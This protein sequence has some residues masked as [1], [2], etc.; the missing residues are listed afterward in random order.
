MARSEP[1]ETSFR[2]GATASEQLVVSVISYA[3]PA[4]GDASDDNWLACLVDVRVGSFRGKYSAC[5]TTAELL[6][7]HADLE[8]LH[9]DLS[10]T[11]TFEAMEGQLD[12][13]ATSDRLGHIRVRGVAMDEA[14]IGHALHFTLFL[15]Q[16]ELAASVAALRK[17]TL[18]FPV[19]M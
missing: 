13:E 3:R 6:H 2:I 8:R 12:F 14:G 17:V 16:T 18:A 5:F 15:D 19:R 7:L 1:R 9:R 11:I 4:T 10:G